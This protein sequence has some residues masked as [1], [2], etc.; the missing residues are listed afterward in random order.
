MENGKLHT[1]EKEEIEESGNEFD[2]HDDE[3]LLWNTEELG[4]DDDFEYQDELQ[5]GSDGVRTA[6]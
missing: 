2:L 4:S 3:D 1:D 6:H 5:E